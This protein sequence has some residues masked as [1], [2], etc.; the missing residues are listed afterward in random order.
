MT[1]DFAKAIDQIHSSGKRIVLAVTGGGSGSISA[2]LGVPGASRSVLEAIVPYQHKALEEWLGGHVEQACAI[3]TAR[4]MAMAA[5]QRAVHLTET[6]DRM[7]LRGIAATASLATD[8]PKRGSHRIHIAWQSAE[9][10]VAMTL[11]LEKDARTRAEEEQLATHLALFAVA[12]AC[13]VEL[14]LPPDI[15]LGE[16]F[17]RAEC[18]APSAWTELLLGKRSTVLVTPAGAKSSGPL[19]LI[20]PG[21]FNPLHSGHLAMAQFAE[22]KFG[23]P[24][25]YEIS[26]T[27][28]DKPPLDF[29]EL[30]SR[31]AQ[32]TDRAVLLTRAPTFVDKALA[33]DMTFLVGADTIQRIGEA[34]YYG[35]DLEARD[36]AID[37]LARM[38]SRFLVFG[39]N[40]AG[41][42]RE[43]DSLDLP[44]AL[45]ALCEGVSTSEFRE[46]V[47]STQ[48]RATNGEQG[49]IG[50]R[51]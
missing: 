31:I 16:N 9:R 36:R 45:H 22:A 20:F 32:F 39:R 4:A 12:E 23:Q 50:Q 48:I 38:N 24:V 44:P 18:H 5:F 27:N 33:P 30:Q 6:V 11:D 42:H 28:V 46:D 19:R 43:L 10:T 15:R 7:K 17:E 3:A 35:N 8:R 1:V 13:E 29:V 41:E 47:S 26:L 49:R 21:A 51:R 14:P 2:L 40:I 34:A 37:R 25:T